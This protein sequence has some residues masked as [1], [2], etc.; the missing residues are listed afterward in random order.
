MTMSRE[1]SPDVLSL[2]L[3][4]PIAMAKA[5]SCARLADAAALLAL[6][7]ITLLALVIHGHYGSGF[8]EVVQDVYGNAI[9]SWY[10]TLGQDTTALTYIDLF[11]Y[12]GLFDT[13]AALLERV[14]PLATSATRHLLSAL[15][16]IAGLAG[17]WLLARRLGG[18]LAGLSAL[19]LLAVTPSWFG[20]MFI[21]PKD[22][23][24]G[25]ALVWALY[26]AVRLVEAAPTPPLRL[27]IAFG[28]AAGA[29]LAIRIGAVIVFAALAAG[30]AAALVRLHQADW[31]AFARSA[32]LLA[33]RTGLPALA[34]AW[35]IM[36][37]FWPYAM[38]DP[39]RH[40]FAALAH[41]AELTSKGG[42]DALF[43]G[44]RISDVWRP[45]YYLPLH[46]VIKLPDLALPLIV[47]AVVLGAGALRRRGW[48]ALDPRLVPVVFVV[49]FPLLWVLLTRP[50]LYDAERHFLFVLPPLA[51]LLGL[52]FSRLVTVARARSVATARA[53]LALFATGLGF[54]AW[55]LV[56]LHPYEYTFYNRLVGGLPGAVDRFE[57]DY[58]GTGLHEALSGLAARLR[59]GEPAPGRVYDVALCGNEDQLRDDL[60]PFLRLVD[61]DAPADFYLSITR[62]HCERDRDGDTILTVTRRGVDFAVVKRLPPQPI[63]TAD[64]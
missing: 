33:V 32:L 6:L 56:E 64:R 9:L 49:A 39:L 28:T 24:L 3:R 2:P 5:W 40:P 53:L 47:A 45:G 29:A 50:Q 37:A 18:A 59:A 7:A 20:T 35:A 22:V 1:S 62:H 54:Q 15:V 42:V 10:A 31:S 41:F 44:Q 38:V 19:L 36:L 60:P 57:T 34:V 11:N 58:W 23:P 30:L 51:A 61:A 14:S 48:A 55:D 17:T 46:I 27:V 4:S 25:T 12:G 43:L 21:N 52:A 8:D 26:A 16:G 13:A 63:D